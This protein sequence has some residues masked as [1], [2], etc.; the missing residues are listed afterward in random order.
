MHT[1]KYNRTR[2]SMILACICPQILS[3]FPARFWRKYRAMPSG[4]SLRLVWSTQG[5][6]AHPNNLTINPHYKEFF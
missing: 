4:D 3:A 6:K 5:H 2:Y 1:V